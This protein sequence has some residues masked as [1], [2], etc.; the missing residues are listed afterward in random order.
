MLQP[1]EEGVLLNTLIL[2]SPEYNLKEQL[3][4][5]DIDNK[6][7]KV[8]ILYDD[9]HIV[10]AADESRTHSLNAAY[11]PTLLQVI[12][13]NI[14]TAFTEIQLKEKR[15]LAREKIESLRFKLLYLF[16]RNFM[17]STYDKN[18]V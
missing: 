7:G 15:K 13:G 17:L 3:K 18:I 2:A 16:G 8:S 4:M 1:G 14:M 9:G 10:N 6:E 12:C 5:A 11:V